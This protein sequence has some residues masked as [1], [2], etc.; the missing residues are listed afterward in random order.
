ML[1]FSV[2]FLPMIWIFIWSEE[3]EIKS[4]QASKTKRDRIF[5][6]PISKLKILV[7]LGR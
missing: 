7:H 2:V 6:M 4:K 3:P 1:K 5:K